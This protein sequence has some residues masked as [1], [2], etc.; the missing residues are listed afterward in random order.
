VGKS[1]NRG[2]AGWG[3]FRGPGTSPVAKGEHREK[4]NAA[5][6]R[7]ILRGIEIEKELIEGQL[8]RKLG[9]GK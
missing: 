3:F 1:G 6:D 8:S 9:G 7:D 4:E 2:D 5:S